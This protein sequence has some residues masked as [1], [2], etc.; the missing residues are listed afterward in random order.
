[1]DWNI[2]LTRQLSETDS[3]DLRYQDTNMTDAIVN[4][5]LN[6]DTDWASLFPGER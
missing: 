5:T 2:G 3:L 4:V 6:R 1:M